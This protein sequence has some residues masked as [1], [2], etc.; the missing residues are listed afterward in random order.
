VKQGSEPLNS[1]E[2]DAVLSTARNTS[3]GSNRK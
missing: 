3:S 2:D 1:R